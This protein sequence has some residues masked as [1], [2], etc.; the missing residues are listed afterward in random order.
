MVVEKILSAG[1]RLPEAWPVDGTTGYDFMTRVAALFVDPAGEEPLTELYAELHRRAGRLRRGRCARKKQQVLRDV[2]GSDLNR[3]TALL[4]EVCERHRRHRDYTRHE[5]HEALREVIACFPVY[6]TY[7]RAPA[8]A[9]VRAGRRATCDE[10]VDAAAARA[11]RTSTASSSTSC[12]DLLLLR[13]PRRRG[14]ASCVMR[15]QQLTGPAMAKGAE[16]TAFYC[17]NRLVSLNEVG[18]DPGRF[19]I[20]VD[21]FHAACAEAQRALAA[22]RCWPPPPT[23][24]S[25]ART[26]ARASHLLSEIPDALGG[27]GA[28]AGR[29]ATSATG[30]AAP[31][32]RNA[33]YLF[34][35]TLVG[36]WPIE[37]GARRRPTW[38]RRRARPRS[39]TSW[40]T[41]ERG[42]RGGAARRSCDDVLADERVRRATWR[43]SWRRWSRPGRVELAG[44]DA[45]Q[46]DRARACPTSTRA[47]SCGT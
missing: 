21:E 40:T 8:G 11:G 20:A 6:R 17:Y 34:Y 7:V 26:C 1:E 46:A 38:R 23:T 24:P 30:A 13:V 47:R 2:L 28:R 33:E 10:A 4:V 15:F 5:L 39:R 3:L 29:S 19:G 31:P 45:A 25:A 12:G 42:L 35:Q 14:G 18:G 27:G 16:D 44:P 22:R 32:D 41:P 9:A 36:A 43:R 37:R